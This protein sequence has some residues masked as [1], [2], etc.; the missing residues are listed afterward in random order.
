MMA[1]KR[2]IGYWLKEL[3][4]LINQ[5]FDEDLAAGEL[6]RRH[7][8]MLHSL[9]EGPRPVDDVRDGLTPFWTDAGE[10][11]VQLTQLVQRG[12]VV[13]DSG[14]LSLTDTG[15]TTHD[16]A[17][18]RIGRRRRAMV[19]GITDEQYLETVRMLET[20]AGNMAGE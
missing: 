19:E 7:W 9:A 18:V 14:A 2:L 5:R 11:D 6:S 1:E 8:Q 17:F 4:R 12:L 15:R 10:W 3:D 16:E 13:E 20:M